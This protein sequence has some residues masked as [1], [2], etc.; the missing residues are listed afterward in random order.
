MT[1]M[2]DLFAYDAWPSRAEDDWGDAARGDSPWDNIDFHID[3]GCGKVPKA[4][5]GIDHLPAPGVAVLA[6]VDRGDVW[7]IAPEPGR[8]AVE[9]VEVDGR[10]FDRHYVGGGRHD[11]Y[12]HGVNYERRRIPLVPWSYPRLPF[13]DDSIESAISHHALEHIG[14]GFIPLMDDIWRVLKH[15]AVFRAIV[16]M[17][18]SWSAVADPDHKRYFCADENF[19]TFDSFCGKPGEPHWLESFSVPYTDARF[20]RVDLDFSPP[21]AEPWSSTDARELRVALVANK[22][23]L[24]SPDG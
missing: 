11:D 8:D 19:C 23:Q 17:F 20:T 13:P 4:R 3:I 2:Q 9:V 22:P 24:E 5:I 12:G 10:H 1:T 18:P 16:P 14:A 7:A 15:G 6:D 21:S